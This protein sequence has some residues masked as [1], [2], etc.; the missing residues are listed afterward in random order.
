MKQTKLTR[1]ARGR[2]CTVRLPGICC[3]DS[4]TVVLAHYRMAG[5]CGTSIKPP[6]L[7]GAWACRTCHDEIDRKTRLMDHETA[8][9][10]H[11]EGMVRTIDTLT[12]EGKIS[13]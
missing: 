11:L 6:D 7:I 5:I 3:G 10:Y 13:A 8:R 12:R 4:E 1:A 9:L 2:D